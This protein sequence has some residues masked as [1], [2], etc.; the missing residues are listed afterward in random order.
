MIFSAKHKLV[1]WHLQP[2]D[3]IESVTKNKN[4]VT[5][6]NIKEENTPSVPTEKDRYKQ[7]VIVYTLTMTPYIHTLVWVKSIE[8]GTMVLEPAN[9]CTDFVTVQIAKCLVKIIPNKPFQV[10][11]TSM[12]NRRL[13]I[14]DQIIV[15]HITD[16]W[17]HLMASE[18]TLL[19]TDL[20]TIDTVHY[21]Q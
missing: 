3:V 20:E 1:P 4:D 8:L 12:S 19:K 11:L 21:K 17:A 2:V 13:H 6:A 15:A 5:P 10:L 14:P 9:E 16:R 7:E 18:A